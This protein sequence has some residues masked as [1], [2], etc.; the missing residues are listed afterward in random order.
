MGKYLKRHASN[1]GH[2]ILTKIYLTWK[3]K[4]EI[5]HQL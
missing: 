2:K 5:W 4:S 1:E 3:S